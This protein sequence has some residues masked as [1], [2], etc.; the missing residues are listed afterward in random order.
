MS[1]GR[2]STTGTTRSC[3]LDHGCS[4]GTRTT[5]GSNEISKSALGT[6]GSGIA[7]NGLVDKGECATRT[8]LNKLLASRTE[9]YWLLAN[10]NSSRSTTT[11]KAIVGTRSTA[12]DDHDVGGIN[13]L[14]HD[15][16]TVT[17]G[18]DA[19]LG[20]GLTYNTESCHGA[21]CSSSA[22]KGCSCRCTWTQPNRRERYG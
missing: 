19:N 4:T 16:T 6:L 15:P 14:G 17:S 18:V 5:A 11:G 8:N 12:T 3:R 2:C 10:E 22:N 9:R 20:I 13:A 1:T 21:I 7:D